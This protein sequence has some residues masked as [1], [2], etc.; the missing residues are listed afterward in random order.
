MSFVPIIPP[1]H[2]ASA[3]TQELGRRIG[4]VIEGF[5]REHPDLKVR[6]IRQAMRL[7]LSGA[8][9]G[10]QAAAVLMGV[11]VAVAAG[12][13]FFFLSFGEGKENHLPTV[14]VGVL[15]AFIALVA[16]KLRNRT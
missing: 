10:P 7:A 8:G 14:M 3:R 2:S 5:R 9:A 11:S 6:E 12:L 16:V 1:R 13:I 15:V 4:E